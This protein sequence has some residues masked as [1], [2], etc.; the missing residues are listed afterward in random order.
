MVCVAPSCVG[1][2][3][4][5]STPKTRCRGAPRGRPLALGARAACRKRRRTRVASVGAVQTGGQQFAHAACRAPTEGDQNSANG[6]MANGWVRESSCHAP[7][8]LNERPKNA[9]VRHK[10]AV[11]HEDTVESCR[12]MFMIGHPATQKAGHTEMVFFNVKCQK[13]L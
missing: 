1:R 8:L 9:P 10:S 3:V 4:V 7:G 11:R 2:H 13:G 5:G 12:S 6:P